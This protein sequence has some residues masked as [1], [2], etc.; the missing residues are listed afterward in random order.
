M[1]HPF[2]KALLVKTPLAKGSHEAPRGFVKDALVKAPLMKQ[3]H[4]HRK[5]DQNVCMSVYMWQA[6][7]FIRGFNRAFTKPL[8]SESPA[9]ESPTGKGLL[10][11]PLGALPRP[12]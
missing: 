7:G 5:K 4:I 10:K 3:P 8:S 9:S 2:A 1:K 12:L 6:R 11:K